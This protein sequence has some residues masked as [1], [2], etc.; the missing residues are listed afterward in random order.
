M[1]AF[2]DFPSDETLKLLICNYNINFMAAWNRWYDEG[3]QTMIR[4]RGNDHEAGGD[5]IQEHE[6]FLRQTSFGPSTRSMGSV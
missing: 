1:D 4:T 5:E 2:Y 3:T 6:T